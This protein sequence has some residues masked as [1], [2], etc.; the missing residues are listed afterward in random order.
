VN[1]RDAMPRGGKLDIEVVNVSVGT[2][3]VEAERG[4][5]IGDYVRV[6]VRESLN[7]GDRI[8]RNFG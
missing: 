2:T 3:S 8:A 4:V 5:P 6:V 7:A 1:A